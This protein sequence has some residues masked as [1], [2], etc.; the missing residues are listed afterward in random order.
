M[1]AGRANP[2]I[3]PVWALPSGTTFRS[4][5][6]HFFIKSAGHVKKCIMSLKL[7]WPFLKDLGEEVYLQ[8]ARAD[9]C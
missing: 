1:E 3:S 5:S 7:L 6:S 9:S 4:G 8:E 2:A